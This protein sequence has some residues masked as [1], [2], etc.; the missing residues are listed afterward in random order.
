LFFLLTA[1]CLNPNQASGQDIPSA[2]T[3]SIHG[4]V[5]NRVTREPIARA[6]VFCPDNRFAAMTD[7]QGRFEFTFPQAAS[8]N[9]TGAASA[10]VVIS[11]GLRRM[12]VNGPNSP[13]MLMARKPGFLPGDNYQPQYQPG[14]PSDQNVTITLIPEALI[15][16]RV[17]LPTSEP[18]DRINV[19]IYRR[20]IQN[21]YGH[22]VSAGTTRTKSNR[23][24]RF[25]ELSAGEYKLFTHELMDIDSQNFPGQQPYGYA[26]VYFPNVS[27]FGSAST[28]VLTAG[29]SFQAEVSLVRQ[30]YYPVKVAVA[31]APP[32]VPLEVQVWAQG[33]QGPGYDLGYNPAEQ[34]IEGLLP[35]GAYSLEVSAMAQMTGGSLNINVRGAALVGSGM[36]LVPIRPVSVNVKEEFT[37]PGNTEPLQMIVGRGTVVGVRGPGAYLSISLE[38]A[39]DFGQTRGGSLRMPSGPQ[40]DSLVIDNV[41]PGRYWVQIGSVRGYAA[42][43]TSGGTDLL[44]EPL[45]VGQGGA[46]SPIDVTMRDDAAELEGTVEDAMSAPGPPMPYAFVYCIPLPDGAGQFA[47]GN[48]SADGKF[49]LSG[50]APGAYRVLAFRGQPADLEY[51]NQEAMRAHETKGHVIRLVG[52]QK[53][54]V[55]LQIS[56]PSE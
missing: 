43:V 4:T 11:G 56:S 49:T 18:P 52:G 45:V 54:Y 35:N 41:Q 17:V 36:T 39:D 28:I 5:V 7:D 47:V 40:D 53:Q 22:W 32:G 8:G 44:H 3:G 42:S 25:S 14:G 37:S 29:K 48:V 50:I 10:G 16:G 51:R 46:S 2:S 34:T 20:Q 13:S 19:E 1:C 27:D 6:L 26:P 15:V 33:H 38:P 31:N 23:E 21:G 9:V 30:A 24:F 55:H 12:L